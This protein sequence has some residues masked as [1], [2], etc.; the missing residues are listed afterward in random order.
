MEARHLQLIPILKFTPTASSYLPCLYV[1]SA[2]AGGGS[3]ARLV[4][5]RGTGARAGVQLQV[6]RALLVARG[7]TVSFS[8]P[9]F[10]TASPSNTSHR[11]TWVYDYYV[12]RRI[13]TSSPKTK[14]GL[15]EVQ[16]C[17]RA[18]LCAC[19]A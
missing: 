19:S 12:T 16:V 14:V 10:M 5:G 6:S 15:P 13:L 7:L 2:S 9:R 4:H 17:A 11:Y 3:R 18:V 1:C 8:T